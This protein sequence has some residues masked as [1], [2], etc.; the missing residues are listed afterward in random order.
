[1]INKVYEPDIRARL[2]TAAHFCEVVAL[3]SENWWR[4]LDAVKR[5]HLGSP[6]VREVNC[7]VTGGELQNQF[8]SAARACLSAMKPA[9]SRGV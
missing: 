6:L 3:T 7:P 5:N 2:G 8:P 1:V 9:K 4:L